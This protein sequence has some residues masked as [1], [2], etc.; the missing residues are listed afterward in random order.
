MAPAQSKPV[1]KQVSTNN[2]RYI[3]PIIGLERPVK[4]TL[5]KGEYVV[6]KC[7]TDPLDEGSSTYDLP[8]PYYS[9]GTPEEWLRF[10]RNVE[11]VFVGQNLTTGPQQ[12]AC[13]R[14]LLEG[15]A[16]TV[17]DL[18]AA[19]LGTQTL[20]HLGEV[21]R[22]LRD[23]VFPQRALQQQKRYMR[24]ALSKPRHMPIRTYVNR[25]LELNDQLENFPGTGNEI[26][27]TKL[28]E[29]EVLDLLEFGIPENWQQAM[30][31]QD[32]DPQVHAVNDFVQFCERLETMEKEE[33]RKRDFNT[34]STKSTKSTR[35]N[36][37]SK[38]RKNRSGKKNLNCMVHGKNC[39]HTSD[40]CF[41]LKKQARR[42]RISAFSTNEQDS[43]YADLHTMIANAV[44]TAV[45][46][47]K[48]KRKLNP[49]K[50]LQTFE[51]LSISDDEVSTGSHVSKNSE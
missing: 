45:K 7:R 28:P 24:R 41:V 29:D 4:P 27:G 44:K 20:E 31:L 43:N 13:V 47:L 38:K 8:I 37:N 48:K 12:Y 15:N 3:V 23:Q 25:V 26:H 22:S 35:L 18:K 16:L 5:T 33:K 36:K 17:F 42:L 11:K 49:S 40:N 9:T 1:E 39:G 14:R 2:V 19:E 46:P 10:V 34:E 6:L 21:L 30:L 50:D 51:E 32:F